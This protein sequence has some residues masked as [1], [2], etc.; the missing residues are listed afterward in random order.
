MMLAG[1]S[2]LALPALYAGLLIWLRGGWQHNRAQLRPC[3][4]H[5]SKAQKHAVSGAASAPEA[6][7]PSF[8]KSELTVE[9]PVLL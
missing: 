8:S 2:L 1:L 5:L 7:S 3:P 6:G 4:T 9:G